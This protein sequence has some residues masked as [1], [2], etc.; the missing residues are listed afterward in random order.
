[1]QQWSAYAEQTPDSVGGPLETMVNALTEGATLQEAREPFEPF[2]TAVADLARQAGLHDAG[3]VH[4][5]QCPMTPVLG[6]GR[7][8]QRTDD[9]RNPF[10][11][12]AMLTC[13]AP[14]N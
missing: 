13:G 7:W 1:L 8:V 6:K 3:V 9:L 11:G 14:I 12:S 4:I 2:S 5:F 10:F